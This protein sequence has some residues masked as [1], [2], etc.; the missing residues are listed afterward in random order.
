MSILHS[1]AIQPTL[2]STPTPLSKSREK[3]HTNKR[4]HTP[5]PLT[6]DI[7]FDHS[8][9][10]WYQQ[11]QTALY[12][13]ILPAFRM[14]SGVLNSILGKSLF[15]KKGIVYFFGGVKVAKMSHIRKWYASGLRILSLPFELKAL[16]TKHSCVFGYACRGIDYQQTVCATGKL[17]QNPLISLLVKNGLKRIKW[18]LVYSVL[19][20]RFS[21]LVLGLLC[22]RLRDKARLLCIRYYARFLIKSFSFNSFGG[23][24]AV[25]WN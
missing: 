19:C 22:I 8:S 2:L 4:K 1:I 5:V 24:W 9:Y 14:L 11:A 10:M 3:N 12:S 13:L 23:R 20:I 15:V 7:T 17:N 25:L 21:I 16:G 18:L 6:N